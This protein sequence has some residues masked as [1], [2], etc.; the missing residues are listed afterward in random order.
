MNWA[1]NRIAAFDTETDGPEPGDARIITAT[2][3]ELGGDRPRKDFKRLLRTERPIPDGAFRVHGISTEHANAEGEHRDEAIDDIAVKLAELLTAGIPVVA[4]NAAYDFT[5]LD[6]ECRRIQAPTLS[7][8]M[9][10]NGAFLGPI[11]DPH[12]IDK[13]VD[14]FRKGSRTL[15]AT[16][17]FYKIDLGKAHDAT[18]DALGAARLAYKLAARYPRIGDADLGELHEQQVAWR[19]EQQAG[20]EENHRQKGKTGGDYDGSW[21]LRPLGAVTS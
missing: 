15:G 8:R 12:V 5:V 13:R 19:A 9:A 16:C 10:M 2:I 17:T 11:I 3:L 7:E 20:L 1:Q 14:K 6:R 4:F 18:A 21:P